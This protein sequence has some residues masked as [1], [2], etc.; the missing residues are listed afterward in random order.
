MDGIEVGGWDGMNLALPFWNFIVGEQTGVTGQPWKY[1][2]LQFLQVIFVI[3][4]FRIYLFMYF[5]R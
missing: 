2:V 3:Y 1:P 5:R 4:S